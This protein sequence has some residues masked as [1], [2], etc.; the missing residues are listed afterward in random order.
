MNKN[1]WHYFNSLETDNTNISVVLDELQILLDIYNKQFSIDLS[2]I[3]E[4]P[5]FIN[6]NSSDSSDS[7]DSNI[8]KKTI[9]FINTH[10]SRD[11]NLQFRQNDINDIKNNTQLI[12]FKFIDSDDIIASISGTFIDIVFKTPVTQITENLSLQKKKA[13]YI[14]NL[15]VHP[16]YRK[17]NIH[18][19][20]ILKIT[21]F[22][23]QNLIDIA[24]FNIK[25][26]INRIPFSF[27]KNY[28]RL[29]D[30][31][32]DKESV[33]DTD[34]NNTQ[35]ISV[36]SYKDRMFK[37]LIYTYNYTQNFKDNYEI[38]TRNRDMV[39]DKTILKITN[40]INQFKQDNYELYNELS[41]DNVKEYFYKKDKY[42]ILFLFGKNESKSLHAV[43][44]FNKILDNINDLVSVKECHKRKGI[45][46]YKNMLQHFYYNK[47]LNLNNIIELMSEFLYYK[48]CDMIYFQQFINYNELK[49]LKLI[50]QGVVVNNNYF[51]FTEK[52]KFK[53][54]ETVYVM[55]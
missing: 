7:S 32:L 33:I 5:L 15:C 49:T 1:F 36:D 28:T 16:D 35:K 30:I 55:T 24:F 25:N 39:S 19:Y 46:C 45:H 6:N 22:A 43:F 34:T 50:E 3:I 10:S 20:L 54:P 14:D 2:K 47:S 48:G 12:V 29:L 11:K 37:N 27:S 52:I 42:E 18:S 41:V 21:Q 51:S 38:V 4:I 17:K 9:D 31:K 53:N 13:I 40:N 26:N 44:I 23:L 8:T